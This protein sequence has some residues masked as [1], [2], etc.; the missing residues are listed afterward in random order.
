[1]AYRNKTKKKLDKGEELTL[2]KNQFNAYVRAR[3]S[4]HD[5]YIQMAKKCDMY[6]RGDQWDEFDMQ[7]LDD[8]R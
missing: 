1:M 2:A 5:E 4:G 3:D 6:Y 7:E 8:P